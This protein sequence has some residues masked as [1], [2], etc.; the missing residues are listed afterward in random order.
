MSS[1][2]KSAHALAE[3]AMSDLPKYDKVALAFNEVAHCVGAD[4][5]HVIWL[6]DLANPLDG[7]GAQC[8]GHAFEAEFV[9]RF[10]NKAQADAI[11]TFQQMAV[12]GIEMAV[13]YKGYQNTDFGRWVQGSGLRTGSHI[14]VRAGQRPVGVICPAR[15]N[16]KRSITLSELE[17]TKPLLDALRPI[18][19]GHSISSVSEDYSR[20]ENPCVLHAGHLLADI[21]G[22]VIHYSGK[23]VEILSL[24]LNIPWGN[25]LS[26]NSAFELSRCLL[27]GLSSEASYKASSQWHCRRQG[28]SVSLFAQTMASA[29]NGMPP[30]ILISM[31]VQVSRLALAVSSPIFSALSLQQQRLA[32]LLILGYTAPQLEIILNVAPSTIKTH[33]KLLFS[34]LGI[35]RRESL[36]DAL[37][38]MGRL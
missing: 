27:S 38:G 30:C 23:A 21:S 10:L 17:K 28:A 32:K 34:R 24:A 31:E 18:F 14:L 26:P 11:L 2:K 13:P 33:T 8:L 1:L 25:T 29:A 22:N 36:F 6:D 5:G 9:E 3:V 12:R 19:C 4:G 15:T 35:F 7:W 16:A 20:C 37:I